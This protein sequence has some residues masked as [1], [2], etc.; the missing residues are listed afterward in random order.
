MGIL[1]ALATDDSIQTERDS[2]GSSFGPIDSGLYN[3]TVSLAYLKTAGS[4]ALAL[5]VELKSDAGQIVRQD[6]WMTS[7]TAKGGKNYY[8]KDGEKHYLP[9][10]TMANSLALLTVGKEIGQLETETKVINLYSSEAKAEV[11]TKVEMFTD[12]LGKEVIAGVIR[13]TVDKNVKDGAGNY[14]PSGE[15]RDENEIDKFFRMRDRMTPAEI[16]AQAEKAVFI[17]TWNEK[18]AGKVRN[19]AKGAAGTAGATK[20]G[21]GLSVAG[22]NPAV[23]KKPTTSLFG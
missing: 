22:G 18:W 6:F 20:P 13:Q 5:A 15:T 2:V 16:R 10:F 17:D 3:M 23:T 9:G 1:A 19:K 7:G 12:L 11:P 8:E 21:T 4:G 14:V